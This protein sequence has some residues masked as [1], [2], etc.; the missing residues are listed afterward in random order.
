MAP[1]DV[2]APDRVGL[3]YLSTLPDGRTRVLHVDDRGALLEEQDADTRDD[4]I[5]WARTVAARIMTPTTARTG[6]RA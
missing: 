3:A 2:P 4:A 1:C 5:A 6:G